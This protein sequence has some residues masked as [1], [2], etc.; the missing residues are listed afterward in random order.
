MQTVCFE[1]LPVVIKALSCRK[2]KTWLVFYKLSCNNNNNINNKNDNDNHHRSISNNANNS[3]NNDNNN[4][5]TRKHKK[6]K[7]TLSNSKNK[8]RLDDNGKCVWEGDL[9]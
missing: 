4:N 3:D 8:P 1:S 6:V 5:D 9:G 7:T 2:K